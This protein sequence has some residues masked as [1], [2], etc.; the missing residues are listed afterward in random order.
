MIKKIWIR[1]RV[2]NTKSRFFDEFENCSN[3][4]KN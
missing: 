3:S 2:L 1:L 4:V